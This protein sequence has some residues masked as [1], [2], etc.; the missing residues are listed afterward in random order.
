MNLL[1]SNDLKC[2]REFSPFDAKAALSQDVEKVVDHDGL[3]S[4]AAVLSVVTQRSS[5]LVWP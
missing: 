5:P 4:Y 2:R 1:G 3:V